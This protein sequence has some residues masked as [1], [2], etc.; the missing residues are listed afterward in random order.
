MFL[1]TKSK[2]SHRSSPLPP[3][4]YSLR[5]WPYTGYHFTLNQVIS[6][7]TELAHSW[8]KERK[9]KKIKIG[10]SSL[11]GCNSIQFYSTSRT[12]ATEAEGAHAGP[13]GRARFQGLWVG[14][15]VPH[16]L[17]LP[18]EG[19]TDPA[20]RQ[21]LVLWQRAGLSGLSLSPQAGTAQLRRDRG[22]REGS[23][24]AGIRRVCRSLYFVAHVGYA[25]SQLCFY[26]IGLEDEQLWEK[27][28]QQLHKV[29]M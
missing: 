6:F 20:S 12:T 14:D 1:I 2:G 17:L 24:S 9:N 28:L 16:F 25:W 15:G 3:C 10:L 11:Q 22:V 23:R 13:S 7:N 29:K 21:H 4:A 26:V 18:N 5:E 8:E 27:L 19:R